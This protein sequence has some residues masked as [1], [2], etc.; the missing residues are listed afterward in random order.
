MGKRGSSLA[1]G[2]RGGSWGGCG[3]GVSGEEEREGNGGRK[4]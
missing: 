3:D 1:R 2:R 4:K